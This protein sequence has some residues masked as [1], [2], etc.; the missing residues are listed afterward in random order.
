M[1]T[2]L[3]LDFKIQM[4]GFVLL[5]T[6]FSIFSL[7]REELINF[8]IAFLWISIL[9]LISMLIRLVLNCKKGV[10]FYG[11]LL[12]SLL[13]WMYVLYEKSKFKFSYSL[14][15]IWILLSIYSGFVYYFFSIFYLVYCYET[16]KSQNKLS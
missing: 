2:F 4:W 3:L 15:S 11:Y 8:I 16:Y 6:L 1:K 10:L 9:Q 14:E 12:F 13:F 5:I 7:I